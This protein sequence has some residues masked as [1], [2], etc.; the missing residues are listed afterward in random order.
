MQYISIQKHKEL[1]LCTELSQQSARSGKL[2]YFKGLDIE[3]IVEELRSRQVNFSCK[4]TK[5]FLEELLESEMKGIKRVPSLFYANP[6]TSFEDNNLAFYECLPCEPLH[7]ITGHIKNLYEEI[8]FHL[9]KKQKKIFK[10]AITKSF[11]G[12][13]VKKG[14][15]YRCS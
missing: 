5:K 1:S 15:D 7:S 14:A 6:M 2:N 12:E 10:D 4:R 3:D 13:E 11:A 8:P 9:E